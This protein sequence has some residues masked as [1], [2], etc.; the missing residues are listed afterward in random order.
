MER[1]I[2]YST[3]ASAKYVAWLRWAL[4]MTGSQ[5]CSKYFK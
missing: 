4:L 3:L 1:D 5:R 2:D